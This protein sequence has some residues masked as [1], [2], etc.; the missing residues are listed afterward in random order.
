[1]IFSPPVTGLENLI[2]HIEH[3]P[4]GAV[5]LLV[6]N[7]QFLFGTIFPFLLI[8]TSNIIIIVT[9]KSAAKSRMSLQAKRADGNQGDTAGSYL[10]RMLIFVSLAYVITSIP[11]RLIQVVLLVADVDLGDIC[12][13]VIYN[14]VIAVCYGI[15]ICNFSINFYM[16][17]V[18]GGKRY[19][20]DTMDIIR[21]LKCCGTK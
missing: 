4:T 13:F 5:L 2:Y 21:S 10:T 15:W 17:C 3:D 14:L 9:V 20:N 6:S 11:Y 12:N 8:I 16:Y 18:A 7:F 19:R 1:M